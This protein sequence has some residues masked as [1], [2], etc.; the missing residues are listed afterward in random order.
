[1]QIKFN[2][3]KKDKIKGKFQKGKKSALLVK[4][5]DA[6]VDEVDKIVDK[7]KDINEIKA[8]LKETLK[9]VSYLL[10]K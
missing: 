9:A 10:N 6:D 4:L 7:A 8:L 2:G 1:M 5:M 3:S